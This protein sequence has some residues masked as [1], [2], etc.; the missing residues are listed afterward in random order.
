MLDRVHQEI[1]H[2]PLEKIVNEPRIREFL[3]G[4]TA[5]VVGLIAGTS[6]ALMRVSIDNIPTAIVFVVALAALFYFKAKFVSRRQ[7]QEEVEV[8]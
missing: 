5:G 4:V 6:L 8:G 1:A 2:D 3:E 7:Q